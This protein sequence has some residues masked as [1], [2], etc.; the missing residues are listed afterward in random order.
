MDWLLLIW[1][2]TERIIAL[3]SVLTLVLL[4]LAVFYGK[5]QVEVARRS[6]QEQSRPFV[7]VDFE[8]RR[9]IAIEIVVTNLGSTM[10]KDV[11]LT[12]IPDLE[13]TLDEPNRRVKNVPFLANP[14]PSLAPAKEHR[15][16][17][18]EAPK[19]RNSDLPGRYE[20]SV[21]YV[22]HDGHDYTDQQTLDLGVFWNAPLIREKT[23]H[24]VWT[25]LDQM[26]QSLHG[27][28]SST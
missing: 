16:L 8:P 19:R 1:W 13:S 10:A 23:L 28:H 3:S 17:F 4:G 26:Q 21:T 25:T 27:I 18:D 2:T 15:V 20:V 7:V 11:A 22:G 14:I 9:R 12:F 5:R 24:D 6:R